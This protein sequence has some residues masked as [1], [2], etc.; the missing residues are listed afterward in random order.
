MRSWKVS[1]NARRTEAILPA[2]LRATNAP[3]P[4][5]ERS[6]HR[7]ANENDGHVAEF[8]V[9]RCPYVAAHL[10][11][12]DTLGKLRQSRNDPAAWIDDRGHSGIGRA[13]HG[14]SRLERAHA[15]YLQ[16]LG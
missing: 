5:R 16:V 3:R 2:F 11:R 14:A 6:D 13:Q 10:A 7:E 8:D 4:Q 15:R 9:R 1:M 12:K